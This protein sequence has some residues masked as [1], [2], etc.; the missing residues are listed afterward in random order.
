MIIK[1]E[2]FEMELNEGCIKFDLS[3]LHVVHAKNLEKRRE[4]LKLVGYGMCLETCLHYIINHRLSLRKEVYS[5]KEYL[6]DFKNEINKLSHI[7][8]IKWEN[9]TEKTET[10]S[11]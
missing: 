2:D 3:I 6:E 4:E 7:A 1:E 8:N 10:L 9:S 11:E 5:L